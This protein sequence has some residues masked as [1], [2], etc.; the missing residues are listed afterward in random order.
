MYLEGQILNPW[1]TLVLVVCSI[2]LILLVIHIVD[3][4]LN[5]GE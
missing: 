3:T 4:I 1:A 2:I 5:E